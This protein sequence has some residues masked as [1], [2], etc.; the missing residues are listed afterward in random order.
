MEVNC[1][2]PF[3]SVRI[4]WLERLKAS[5][6]KLHTAQTVKLTMIHVIELILDKGDNLQMEEPL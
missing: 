1:A 3:S 6:F 2:E 4:P 5:L